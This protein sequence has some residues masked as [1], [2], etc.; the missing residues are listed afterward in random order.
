M[1]G[2]DDKEY[3]WASPFGCEL[4]L[5][6]R[7]R[8]GRRGRWARGDPH[9]AGLLLAGCLLHVLVGAFVVTILTYE[10]MIDRLCCFQL[11]TSGS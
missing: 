4:G 5:L 10:D 2:R 6:G 1:E 8:A 7:Q 3:L 11:L 9:E